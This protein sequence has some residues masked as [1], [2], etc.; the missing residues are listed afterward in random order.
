MF[1]TPPNCHESTSRTYFDI[2]STPFDMK[3]A[4]SNGNFRT[5]WKPPN[6]CFLLC[7]RKNTILCL[8]LMT[9]E[10]SLACCFA[11][12]AKDCHAHRDVLYMHWYTTYSAAK[13]R[14]HICTTRDDQLRPTSFPLRALQFPLKGPIVLLWK[15]RVESGFLTKMSLLGFSYR[16]VVCA[17]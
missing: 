5:S 7:F 17:K 8:V 11:L 12:L 13:F 4:W 9:W 14:P 1:S 3:L 2:I 10:T 6:S 16:F 15:F